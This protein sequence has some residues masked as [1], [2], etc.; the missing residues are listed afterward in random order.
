MV[1]AETSG[2]VVHRSNGCVE[3]PADQHERG[4]IR[5]EGDPRGAANARGSW[6]TPT[7]QVKA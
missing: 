1:T 6:P 5:A 2:R 7:R 4:R 3:N